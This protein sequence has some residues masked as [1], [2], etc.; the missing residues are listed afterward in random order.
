MLRLLT[1]TGLLIASA[2]SFATTTTTE[3]DLADLDNSDSNYWTSYGVDENGDGTTYNYGSYQGYSEINFT[4]DDNTLTITGWADTDGWA[5]DENGNWVKDGELDQGK[6]HYWGD[7]NGWGLVNGD[8]DDNDYPGHSI[9][10]Q[11]DYDMVLLS[12]ENEVSLEGLTVGWSYD[13]TSGSDVTQLAVHSLSSEPNFN[14]NS[15]DTW[16]EVFNNSSTSST[17]TFNNSAAPNGYYTSGGTTGSNG[18][19]KYWLVGVLDVVYNCYV[20]MDGFKL[21]GVTASNGTTVTEVPEPS[22]M[23]LFLIAAAFIYRKQTSA[24]NEAPNMKL[25]C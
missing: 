4:S 22:T 9:D 21:L 10:N 12:F 7:S 1:I 17:I 6:M 20:D 5:K 15:N 14:S 16:S 13:G 2:S 24:K 19:S 23:A 25:A 18:M 3:W 8:E 11:Y